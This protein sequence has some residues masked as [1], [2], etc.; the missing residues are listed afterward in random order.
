MS[1]RSCGSENQTKFASEITIHIL[2]LE[3]VNKP[4]VMVFPKLLLC[5]NCGF[6]EFTIAENEMHLL[7]RDPLRGS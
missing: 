4:T 1:C 5:M 3:N 7:G 6:T 2:G